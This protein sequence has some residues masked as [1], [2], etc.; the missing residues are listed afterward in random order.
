MLSTATGPMLGGITPMIA[1][2]D[3]DEGGDMTG[4]S[5][6]EL[7]VNTTLV[8]RGVVLIGVGG[9]LAL[10]GVALGSSAL[11]AATRRWVEQLE[12]PPTELARRSWEQAKAATTAGADAWRHGTPG[13]GGSS[14]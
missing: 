7:Q 11:L 14:E 6:P 8:T 13:Q 10:T 3:D 5:R 9:A 4:I 2:T 1:V 12:T